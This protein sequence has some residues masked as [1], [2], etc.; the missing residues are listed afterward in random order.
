MDGSRG[1]P[2]PLAA[3]GHAYARAGNSRGAR[4]ALDSVAELSR[5][6]YVSAYLS[7]LIYTGLGE[8]QLALDSLERA[9]HERDSWLVWLK[10]E[11]RFGCLRTSPRFK[12]FLRILR[13]EG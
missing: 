11:P 12:E 1:N 10:T 6:H 13:F 3:L 2:A 5:H 8:E 9:V 7:A 4:W